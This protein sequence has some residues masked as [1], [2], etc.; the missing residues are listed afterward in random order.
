MS[1]FSIPAPATAILER[2]E[3]AGHEAWAVGGCVRDSL[4][5]LSP[6][7]WDLCTSATPEEM[8]AA[9]GDWTVIPTG[10]RHGTLTVRLEKENWE[11]TTFRA[12][13]EYSDHRRPDQVR[14]VSR[15]EEDLSRRDFTDRKSVV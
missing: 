10:L 11:V 3:A 4:L 8:A 12:D 7:D 9:F 13:G 2:L 15:V 14:F 1:A 5:G 6:H